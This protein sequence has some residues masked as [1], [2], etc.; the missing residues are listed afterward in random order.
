MVKVKDNFYGT[1]SYVEEGSIAKE[2]GIKPGDRIEEINSVCPRD[3]IDFSFL[4]SDE[5]VIMKVIGRD[6]AEIVYEIEKEIDEPLGVVFESGVFDGIR[7]CSNSCIFCFVD[8]MAPGCRKTLYKKDDDYRMSFLQGNFI[9]L[10]NMGDEDFARIKR[11]HLSPLYI[12]VHATDPDTRIRMMNNRRAGQIMER[13][14]ELSDAGI[15][16]HCQ[17][18]LC[19]GINDGKN[20]EKT[21]LDIGNI[22]NVVSLAVVPVGITRYRKNR[23]PISPFSAA[24]S[25]EVLNLADRYN[26]LYERG[27][28]IYPADEFYISAGKSFP[29]ADEYDGFPQLENGIGLSRCFI[30][31]LVEALEKTEDVGC[32]GKKFVFITGVLAAEVIKEAAATIMSKIG[33]TIETVPL[34]NSFFGETVTVTGLLTGKDISRYLKNRAK[35]KE[36]GREE[37]LAVPDVMLREFSDS[38]LDDIVVD[39]IR[40]MTDMKVI[41]VSTVPGEL[42]KQITAECGV[43]I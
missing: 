42:V 14:K 2:L 30:D 17:V 15:K 39:D 10:T 9:T 36:D 3:L 5:T 27:R 34:V 37:I 26:R 43:K 11:L 40:K 25:L 8:Q 16:M 7:D 31:N 20:L 35:E 6:G 32:A 13:L 1:V 19:K 29:A 23:V 24:D 28:Y 21:F 38:F 4:W 33:C 12:S 22:P 18:V 41:T